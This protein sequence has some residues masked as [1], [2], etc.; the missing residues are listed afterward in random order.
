MLDQT[1]KKLLTLCYIFN[2]ANQILLGLSKRGAGEGKWNGFGGKVE[3]GETIEE[4]TKREVLEESG[5]TIIDMEKVAILNFD[6]PGEE[7]IWQT[8]VF[9][10]TKYNGNPIETPEMNPKWFAISDIPYEKMWAD[11]EFWLPQFL[12]GK[13]LKGDF[14]FETFNK[15]KEHDVRA[16]DNL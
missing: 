8:H 7:K 3:P 14:L 2:D 9:K 6:L 11:D 13:K 4:A 1:N 16:V 12:E 10:A 5:I 15:V